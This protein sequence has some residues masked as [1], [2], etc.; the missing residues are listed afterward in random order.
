M[1]FGLQVIR[2]VA[3]NDSKWNEVMRPAIKDYAVALVALF[4]AGEKCGLS[5]KD[6]VALISASLE[7]CKSE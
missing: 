5:H 6:I 7:Q 2:I 1:D 3:M 4:E